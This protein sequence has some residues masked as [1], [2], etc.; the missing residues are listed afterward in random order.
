MATEVTQIRNI[1]IIGQGGGGK[2]SLADAILFAAG[3]TTRR[4]SVDDGS[5]AFDFEPEET[6]RKLSLVTSFHHATW[7]K[8]QITLVDTP[9]YINF[10]TDGLNS[11]RACT[12]AVFVLEPSAGSAKV[13]AE[14]IWGRAEQ[15]A[16][17]CIGFVTKMDRE[18]ANFEAALK[19]MSDVLH[20][21]PVPVQ[22]PIGS[23]ENFRGV[24]DLIGMR[25]LISQPDGSTKE[26]PIPADLMDEAKAAR[27]KL[28]ESAAETDDAL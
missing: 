18:N 22:L 21:K 11:M 24:V 1:G 15:L 19:D 14:R 8:Y 5:S 26:E 16:L 10:L 4:G 6:R 2:T 13:E 25:A 12:A 20:G 3:A 27:E 9:G 23:A 7:K 28:L 17:P